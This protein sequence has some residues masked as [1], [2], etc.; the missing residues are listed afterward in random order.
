[1]MELE[2]SGDAGYVCADIV[3]LA[4]AYGSLVLQV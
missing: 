2:I 4:W 3:T 1:M